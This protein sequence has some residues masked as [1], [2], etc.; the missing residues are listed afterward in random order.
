MFTSNAKKVPW[1]KELHR[2]VR[3]CCSILRAPDWFT[4]PEQEMTSFPSVSV[5]KR[6]TKKKRNAPM[7]F[8][9]CLTVD[10][11]FFFLPS[12]APAHIVCSAW[13]LTK[14]V[15]SNVTTTY[16]ENWQNR[17][18]AVS[19]VASATPRKTAGGAVE[20]L[21]PAPVWHWLTVC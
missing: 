16:G 5:L 2:R 6:Q 3:V 19:N 15:Q 20:P 14:A 1:A 7:L 10:L 4:E 21:T 13:Q 17:L 12:G 18:L 9:I 8:G 11:C